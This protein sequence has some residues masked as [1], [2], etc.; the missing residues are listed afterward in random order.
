M[1]WLENA[2]GKWTVSHR[3]WIII[4]T[5]IAALTAGSGIRFLTFNNDLRVFFSEENPQLQALEEL[6]NTYNRIDN[7]LFVVAP[8][9]GTV[10]TNETLAAVEGLTGAAWQIPYSSRIDSITNFQHASAEGDDLI[11]RDLVEGAE[12]L[13]DED[14]MQIK[15]SVL[16]EPLLVN[17]LVSPSGH[18]TSIN[19]NVLM[20]GESIQEVPEVARFARSLADDFRKKYPDIKIY[21]T[22]AVMFDNAFGEATANDMSTLV[23]IMF[24]VII[25]LIGLTLRSIAGTFSTLIIILLS[26]VTGM[27]LAGWMGISL[28]TASSSAPTI[29]LVL[30]VADSVHILVTVFQRMRQGTAKGEAIAESLRINLQ[31]VF[32]T[33]ITTTIGFLTMNFSDAPPFRDLGNIVAMGVM[34]AFIYSVAFLPALLAVIPVRIRPRASGTGA[35]C[36]SCDKLADFVISWRRP[37]FWGTLLVAVVMAMGITKIELN[38]DWVKY[39]DKRYSIRTATDFTIENLSGFD[40]IEYSLNTGETGGIN[41][42]EYLATVDAFADWYRRQPDVVH[43][44]TITDTYKRLNRNM[45]GDDEAYSR[46]PD[47]RDLAAQYMLLYEMSLP[48]GLDLNNYIDV[49][50]SATRMIVTFR[51]MTTRKIREMDERGREWLKRNAPE[52]MFTYGSGLSIIWAHISH[53]NINKMLSASL[54]A[55]VLISGL[56]VFAMRSFKLGILSL[57]PNLSPAFMAFGLWGIVVGRVGLGLSVVVAMTL[58][59]VVDDTVHFMTKYLR[60]R[61][62]YKMDKHNAVRYSFNTVGTAMWVTTIALV[63]GFLVLTFSGFK[64]NSE[65]GLLTA[66]TITLALT[67]DFLFLPTLLMK[68]DRQADTK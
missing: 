9:S 63:A 45:H 60:A 46:I 53:R 35:V 32:L 28:N 4:F 13:S 49:D 18:V 44:N 42:P 2:L 6:E 24:F 54:L 51:N 55:L 10:F 21:I 31:P 19:V 47:Q 1:T 25:I 8:K 17:R 22:G 16:A 5:T 50:K 57:V 15:L 64:L 43:V 67:M 48:F 52:E 12:A 66:I 40:I 68:V 61:R 36:R 20:P 56:M 41:N 3:W 37:L 29:I 23:P 34:A 58:G 27:G 11:V 26:M 33:S 14:I 30:A 39:F 7:V 59:I 62:E 65:M 38:D